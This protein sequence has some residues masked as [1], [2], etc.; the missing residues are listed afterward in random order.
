MLKDA[1]TAFILL[2]AFL[3]LGLTSAVWANGP[4][5]Q[6]IGEKQEELHPY[7]GLDYFCTPAAQSPTINALQKRPTLP[8]QSSRGEMPNLGF[9]NQH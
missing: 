8:W 4:E 5:L 3:S 6:I 2:I 7:Q 1:K 9:T